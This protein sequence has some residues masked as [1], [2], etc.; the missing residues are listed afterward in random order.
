M[1]WNPSATAS[2]IDAEQN[3]DLIEEDFRTC[4]KPA[5]EKSKPKTLAAGAFHPGGKRS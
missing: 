1:V 2:L 4:G 3:L 5:W